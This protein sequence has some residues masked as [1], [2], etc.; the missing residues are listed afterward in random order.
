MAEKLT[1]V[2]CKFLQFD[3][4]DEGYCHASKMGGPLNCKDADYNAKSYWPPCVK[5]FLKGNPDSERI[6]NEQFRGK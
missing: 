5:S 1:N 3:N 2:D 6:Y 4:R